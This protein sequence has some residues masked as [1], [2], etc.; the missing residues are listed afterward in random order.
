MFKVVKQEGRDTATTSYE[1]W[2]YVCSI[3]GDVMCVDNIDG[4]VGGS[5]YI[6][7]VD[8]GTITVAILETTYEI[9]YDNIREQRLVD[10][11]EDIS[12]LDVRSI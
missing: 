3:L 12:D 1:T 6:E 10:I 2:G 5:T 4:T 11:I 7:E 8:K 9:T